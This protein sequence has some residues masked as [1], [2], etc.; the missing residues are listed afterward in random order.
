MGLLQELWAGREPAGWAGPFVCG[1]LTWLWQPPG[2]QSSGTVC[3]G[4]APCL[5]SVCYARL[6]KAAH[7]GR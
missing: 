7:L 4:V 2:Q 6:Q 5:L 3:S 1:S